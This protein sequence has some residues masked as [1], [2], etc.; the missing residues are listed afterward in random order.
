MAY[1][2]IQICN[3]ALASLGE[4]FIRSLDEGNKRAKM[5]DIFYDITRDYL[6]TKFDWP[7]AR[8]V[9]KLQAVDTE[10][11]TIPSGQFVFQL[12]NDCKTPRDIH[13][14][15]SRT[16]WEI[17]KDQLYAK[18]PVV[19]LYYT[20]KEIAT[21]YFSDTFSNLLA[22]GLAVR[23]APVITQDEVLTKAL[24]QQY[25]DTTMEVWESE[26]NIGND[27]RAYDE[28]PDNDTFVYPTGYIDPLDSGVE[29]AK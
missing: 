6:L 5:C 16:W 8:R 20:A 11:L 10:G 7:F 28:D 17:R 24:F 19:Y 15:G 14:P 13:P 27:Y 26:A 12:P 25:K 4:D 1:S 23:L 9:V 21:G 2:K 18:V 3:L 29:I 22:L